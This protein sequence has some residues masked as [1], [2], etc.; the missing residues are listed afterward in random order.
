VGSKLVIAGG[1][2][3]VTIIIA[4]A[5]LFVA[6][7]ATPAITV[8][9]VSS[10]KQSDNSIWA[11][12][13]ISNHTG[14]FYIALPDCVEVHHDG[15]WTKSPSLGSPGP[16]AQNLR[17][18]SRI[19]PTIVLTN[20]PTATPLRLKMVGE[21]ELAGPL[22]FLVWLKMRYVKQAKLPRPFFSKRGTHF[23]VYQNPIQI[24]SDEFVEAEQK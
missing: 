19:F 5:L 3:I 24:V 13:E 11:C 20:V 2:F 6:R 15:V 18:H 21:K 17:P 4:A 8:R 1:A 12:F 14:A 23:Y 7:P 10:S 22:G 9:H 16:I